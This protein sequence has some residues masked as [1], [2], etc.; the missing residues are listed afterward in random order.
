MCRA[1]QYC[2][3]T[4][5]CDIQN[6]CIVRH[7]WHHERHAYRSSGKANFSVELSSPLCS[8]TSGNV[9]RNVYMVVQDWSLLVSNGVTSVHEQLLAIMCCAQVETLPNFYAVLG[10]EKTATPASIDT[11][12]RSSRPCNT[13]LQHSHSAVHCRPLCTSA[14]SL[15]PR[16]SFC[17]FV[18]HGSVSTTGVRCLCQ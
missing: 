18:S 11:A 15:S 8:Q 13:C 12:F 3:I 1:G 17:F 6:L 2:V 14:S 9:G 7:V 10:L 16:S 5:Q 4:H